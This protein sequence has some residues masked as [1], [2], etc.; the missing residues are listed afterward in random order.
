MF[1]F[2]G[3][4]KGFSE[5]IILGLKLN[6]G[7]LFIYLVFEE[8]KERFSLIVFTISEFELKCS[9]NGKELILDKIILLEPSN[10]VYFNKLF[11]SM[12]SFF[13]FFFYKRLFFIGI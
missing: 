5:I 10:F 8:I 12:S 13:F 6:F 1:I 3:G 4:R 11:C 9:F 7:I 2:F